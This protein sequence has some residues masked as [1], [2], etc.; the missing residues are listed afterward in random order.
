[1]HP[2]SSPFAGVVIVVVVA[3]ASSLDRRILDRNQVPTIDV[4][5][6]ERNVETEPERATVPTKETSR[7]R[8]VR[9]T[10]TRRRIEAKEEAIERR[11]RI[12]GRPRRR[13]RRRRHVPLAKWWCAR[14]HSRPVQLYSEMQVYDI[15]ARRRMRSG[16]L[17]TDTRQSLA[18]G[19]IYR[20]S[21]GGI[22]RAEF[23]VEDHPRV[24]FRKSCWI[25]VGVIYFRREESIEE[26]PYWNL[27]PQRGGFRFY[28]SCQS[29]NGLNGNRFTSQ[30]YIDRAL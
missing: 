11:R 26:G 21:E 28:V 23:S 18:G 8:W 29:D 12:I 13:R 16:R 30:N 3:P 10:W 24:C 2:Q 19:I 22:R 27:K 6:R 5:M 1:M 17:C 15:D 14:Q 20:R 7:R 25:I 9:W 4:Q